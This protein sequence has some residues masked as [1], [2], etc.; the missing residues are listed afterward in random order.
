MQDLEKKIDDTTTMMALAALMFF[1]PFV[2]H[3]MRSHVPPLS[4]KDKAF[5]GGYCTLG[6]ITLFLLV[7]SSGLGIASY[8]YVS[9]ALTIGYAVSI[10][11][12]LLLLLVG[13]LCI[14][15]NVPLH[16]DSSAPVFF[17]PLQE[18]KSAILYFLPLYNIWARYHLH[19][20]QSPNR[21]LKESLLRWTFFLVLCVSNHPLLISVLVIIITLRA[22]TLF[23]GIDVLSLKV[24]DQVNA[25]FNKN[26][27]ELR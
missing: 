24:K 2:L 4:D 9:P 8:L 16:L 25:L 23:V 27:E 20:F 1:S 12:L 13:S 7:L 10:G 14:I 11:I 5:V 22:A 17:A 26:P 21:W 19:S 15:A 6:Y 3:M 18:K